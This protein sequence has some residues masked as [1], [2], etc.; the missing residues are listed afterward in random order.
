MPLHRKY[1]LPLF[2][3]LENSPSSSSTALQ[4]V[5][6]D[7]D[8]SALATTILQYSSLSPGPLLS[9]WQQTIL[10]I[11]FALVEKCFI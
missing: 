5:L 6:Q 10:Q 11:T 9:A 8:I 7:D 2:V 1:D 3:S 4:I